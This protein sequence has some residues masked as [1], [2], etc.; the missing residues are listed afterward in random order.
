[1]TVP[2]VDTYV[3]ACAVNSDDSRV[4]FFRVKSERPEKLVT[5]VDLRVVFD[6]RID[7]AD[8]LAAVDMFRE[9]LTALQPW[10]PK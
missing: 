2:T 8:V 1:M 7:R 9:Y 4:R 5:A 3:D 10:P 6:D